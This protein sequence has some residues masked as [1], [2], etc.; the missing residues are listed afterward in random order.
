MTPADF[1]TLAVQDVSRH[2]GR[3]RAV[4]RVTFTARRGSILGLLGPNGA[5]KSTL[6]ALLAT[7]LRPSSGVIRYGDTVDGGPGSASSATTS[8]STRN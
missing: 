6:L 2:F 4:A 5:G 3:R 8:S 7:L 1:D